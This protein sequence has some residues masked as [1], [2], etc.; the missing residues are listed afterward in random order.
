MRRLNFP[1]VVEIAEPVRGL[2]KRAMY[3]FH[4]R[5]GIVAHPVYKIYEKNGRR[6]VR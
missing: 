2:R 5:L 4:A 6:S 3:D 1:Y